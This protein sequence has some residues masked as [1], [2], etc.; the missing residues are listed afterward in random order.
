[1]KTPLPN[2]RTAERSLETVKCQ[3]SL[4]FASDLGLVIAHQVFTRSLL[5]GTGGHVGI[6]NTLEPTESGR[7]RQSSRT[8]RIRNIMEFNDLDPCFVRRSSRLCTLGTSVA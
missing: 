6:L 1:M 5:L 4:H 3:E 7:E 8:D 2:S